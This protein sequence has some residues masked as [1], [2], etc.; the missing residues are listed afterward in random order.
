MI[1][2]GETRMD[3]CNPSYYDNRELSWLAFNVRVLAEAEDKTNPILERLKFL[4]ITASNLD[5]F[6][7][8]RVSCVMDQIVAEVDKQE[9]SGMLPP[10]QLCAI[11]KKA[12]EFSQKQYACLT[13]SI[14]PALE[15]EGGASVRSFEN[16]TDDDLA[17]VKAYFD[18]TIYPIVTP[19]AIDQSRPFPLLNNKSLN[20]IVELKGKK[21]QG[22]SICFAVVQVPTVVPRL[23][24]LPG[25][26]DG[27]QAFVCLEDVMKVHIHKLFAG[28]K[29]KGAAAFRITRDSDFEIDEEDAQDVLMKVEKSLKRRKFGEPVRIE[30]E[31]A[32]PP[33]ARDF[34]ESSLNVEKDQMFEI[35]G[36]LDLTMFMAFVNAKGHEHL[37]HKPLVPQPCV[38][39]INVN[40]FE[41][42]KQK[43]I[44]VH[45]PYESFDC[46]VAF[47]EAAARDSNVLAIK[48]TL[49]RVSGDSPIVNAL[50]QA[51]ENGKQV[52]VMVE[53][54]ARFD[55]E[56]NILWARRLEKSGAHVVYGLVGLKIHCK[57]CLVVRRE[58]DGIRR[59]VH[60]GTGNYNDTTAKFYT[61]LG[62]FTCKNRY[63]QDMSA[64]FNMLTG[65][66]ANADWHK[67]SVAPIALRDTFIQYIEKET[68]NAKAG[69]PARIIAK[70]NA[71]VDVP[72]IQALYRASMAGVKIK[73]IV[74]GICCLKPGL[75]PISQNIAVFSIVDRFL[76]HS[77][78]FYFENAGDH[79][80]LLSSADWMPRNFD[81]R[82]EI[83]FPITDDYLKEKIVK[84]LD[85]TL[86]DTVKLRT[87]RADGTYEKTRRHG[88]ENAHLQSQIAFH[89]MAVERYLALEANVNTG[90]FRPIYSDFSS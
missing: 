35:D 79:Q 52:T 15:K 27:K 17:F 47:F 72:I 9:P 65:Y 11:L 89:Q 7:M 71:L 54:Q 8:I 66:S 20:I 39:F 69:K 73:L 19:M 60:L 84:I 75:K 67:I 62:F 24:R 36:P 18:G 56:N 78:I 26:R 64:L 28:Y 53:L 80:V 14:L 25:N 50:M 58:A 42:I 23:L 43:D 29:V 5:E 3:L 13:G 31:K 33:S 55:E 10:E 4:A 76:E 90:V 48:A 40:A 38:D 51:A 1:F 16:L 87:K 22:K 59:Y 34:L 12:R 63:G 45:H 88:R 2:K 86:A 30:I 61:D 6:F 81:K 70:I 85:I 41:A 44:L 32:M 74:R 37:R 57:L 82:V 83:A 21:E 77:R 49:Y 68:A 46:V